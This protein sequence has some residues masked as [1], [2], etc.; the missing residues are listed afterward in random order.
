M[1]VALPGSCG[2]FSQ[3]QLALK[4]SS[5]GHLRLDRGVYDAIAD[6]TWISKNLSSRP[7][8]LYEL[9]ELPPNGHGATDACKHCM[10]GVMFACRNL[11]IPPT[12]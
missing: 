8:R 7:T 2:L 4:E 12:L 3:L 1:S 5:Q 6:F 11:P 9:V 10:G